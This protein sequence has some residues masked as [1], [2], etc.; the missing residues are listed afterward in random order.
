MTLITSEILESPSEVT[1][2]LTTYFKAPDLMRLIIDARSFSGVLPVSTADIP[3]GK[4]ERISS[5]CAMV[6]P[7]IIT[8][9]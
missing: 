3:G 5:Q 7:K 4:L 2:T 9:P 8:P 1:F 6:E